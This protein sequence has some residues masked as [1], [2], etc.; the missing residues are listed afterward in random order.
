MSFLQDNKLVKTSVDRTI[1]FVLFT[2]VLFFLYRNPL[3]QLVILQ[4]IVL[5]VK[6]L[7]TI[8]GFNLCYATCIHTYI[9]IERERKRE[10]EKER[11]REGGC[12]HGV[13]VKSDGLRIRSTRVRTL[14]VLLRSLLGKYPWERYEPPYPPSCGLNSTTTILLG[15][16]LWH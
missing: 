10:R 9:Y 16:W 14:V 1:T 2:S 5:P 8:Y 7:V 12:P 11:E 6:L 4:N 13:M 3:V 15:K